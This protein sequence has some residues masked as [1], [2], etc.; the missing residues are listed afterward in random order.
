MWRH[1]TGEVRKIPAF[2]RRD[3]L[4]AWSYRG[5]FFSEI[6]GVLLQVGVFYFLSFLV[7]PTR[8]PRVGQTRADYMGFVAVGLSIALVYQIGVTRLLTGVRNEQLMGT[9]EALLTTPTSPTTIQVGMVAYDLLRIPIRMGVLLG[10]AAG[11]F[12]VHLHWLGLVQAFVIGFA[13]LPFAWGVA[14]GLTALVIV[15]RQATSLIGLANYAL[16]IGSGTYFPV[17]MLPR[18]FAEPAALN[19]LAVAL[20]GTRGA[21]LAGTGWPET[22]GQVLLILP[23]GLLTWA[24]GSVIFRVALQHERRAGTLALY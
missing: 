12:G 24:I 14:A 4:V 13:F 11:V 8:M 6:G 18:W 15:F 22:L 5:A 9:L 20:Q 16:L 21:L 17:A 1:L 19:P 7:D 3:M 10:V 23:V 2:A